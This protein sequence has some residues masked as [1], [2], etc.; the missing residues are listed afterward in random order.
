MALSEVE[1]VVL[2]SQAEVLYRS[3]FLSP[4][5]RDE[6]LK[7]ERSGNLVQG[8]FDPGNGTLAAERLNNYVEDN[9]SGRPF[10]VYTY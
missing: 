10:T 6:F 1:S 9:G 3:S 2:K 5:K 7:D 8:P 4:K